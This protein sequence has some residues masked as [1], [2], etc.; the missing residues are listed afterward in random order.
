LFLLRAT[1]QNRFAFAS[2]NI[3]LSHFRVKA[4]LER[5]FRVCGTQQKN[6]LAA[7]IGVLLFFSSGSSLALLEP[8]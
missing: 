2:E 7:V 3:F 4:Q 6:R 8:D 5:M 1:S